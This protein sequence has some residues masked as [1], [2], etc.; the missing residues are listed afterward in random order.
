M[1]WDMDIVH[2]NDIYLADTDYW[3]RL[4]E[5]ICYDP[6]FKAYLDFDRG[7]CERF[8]AP[9]H[10]PML[11]ENML[12]Y[13]GPRVV[14]PPSAHEQSTDIHHYQSLLT[15]VMTH[16]S[17]CLCHLSVNPVTFGEFDAVTPSDGHASTNHEFP[18]YTQQVLHFSWA[19]YSFGGGHFASTIS[20]R[21]LPFCVKL[22]CDQYDFG[23]AL[24]REFTQCT[25]IFEHGK[26]ILNHI[27]SSGDCSQL[28]GYLIHSLRFRDSD[29]TSHFWQLQTSIVAELRALRSLQVIVAIV[30][31]DH[32]GKCV[33]SFYN[34]LKSAGWCLSS[35]ETSFPTH[36]DTISGSCRILIGLHTSC[37]P[38][39]EPLQLKSPPPSMLRPLRLSLWEP[40]NRTEYSV[41]LAM[42]DDDF[43]RQ[44]VKFTATLPPST[45]IHS[46]G[47][48]LK[49]FLHGCHSDES[50]FAGAAVISSDGLAHHLTQAQI[51]TYFNT[52]SAL[53]STMATIHA[54]VTFRHLNL[55]AVFGFIDDLTYRLS[56]PAN[57]FSLDA[58]VP[59]L[60][61]AWLLEQVHAHLIFIRD[62]NCKIFSPNQFAAPAETIQAFVNG[63]ISAHLLS[64]AQWVEAYA[65]DPECCAIRDLVLSPGKICKETLKSVHYTYRQPLR[66]SFI[67]IED[68]LL[69]F[70]EP[71]RG[72]TSYTRLQ[73]VPKG[74]YDIIFIAFHSNPIGGRHLNAYRTLHGL[75]L[76]YHWPEM[77][78]F[79]KRM[80]SAC[81]GCALANPTRSTSSE[82]VYH[83]PIDAPFRVLFVDGYSAGKHSGFEGC[84]VYLIAACGMTGFS[85]ME[86]I[87]HATSSSFAS[88]IMKIQ[89]RFGLC[90]TIVLDKDS[91][92]FGVFKEAVDLLQINRHVLSGG[93]HNGMLVEIPD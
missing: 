37:A 20:S 66:Q 27:R 80:C 88:G 34:A 23:R 30:I 90:H 12:Y 31:T 28:H 24:F 89:L 19:V 92:F 81:P 48:S 26:D 79:I 9:T 76:R 35:T 43:M 25:Q 17:N 33:K 38:T 65:A 21:S 82:L 72:S 70:W 63:A 6:L 54:S 91:K 32:D 15:Q 83:F 69:I 67:V 10:L 47:V 8:P 39:V 78:S 46:P 13:R 18:C 62:S 75:R 41:S 42:D 4:G 77:Y 36:G 64:H 3:S 87:Q 61:S 1:C 11:P 74:L 29:T 57:K 50:M 56:Q 44:D 7:L 55:H 71:I 14:P 59:A 45:L 93:N 40:F 5:D 49:Y 22:A 58:A 60:T 52:S 51:R 53:N 68:D 86:P 16:A 2:R 85:V 84:E 73:I